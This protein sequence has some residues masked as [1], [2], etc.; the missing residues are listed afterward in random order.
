VFLGH[1]AVAFAAKKVAPQT[2]L[3]TMFVAV[4][5]ADI[6]FP[7][8][9]LLGVESMRLVPGFTAINPFD[10]YHM[11]WSH[12]LLMDLV[13]ALL[14]A[15]LYFA[16]RRYATGALLAGMGVLSHWLLDWLTHRPDMALYPGGAKYGLALWMSAGGTI[17]LETMMFALGLALYRS[18]TRARDRAGSIGLYALAAFLYAL[19]IA[20]IFGP[21][22]PGITTLAVSMVILTGILLAWTAGLDRHREAR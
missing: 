3:A 20:S 7:V 21:P 12:S 2:S 5:L 22:P 8:F 16:R 1:F 4:N 13:W 18:A 9:L 17:A 14:F 10:L 11:P 15:G 19:Y 6:L